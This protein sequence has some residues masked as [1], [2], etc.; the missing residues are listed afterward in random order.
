VVPLLGVAVTLGLI[1]GASRSQLAGGLAA[2]GAGAVLYAVSRRYR[3]DDPA[4]RS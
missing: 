4:R 2:A 1:A 3:P